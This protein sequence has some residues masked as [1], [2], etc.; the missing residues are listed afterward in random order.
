MTN[1]LYLSYDGI[2]DPLGQ[3]QILPYLKALSQKSYFFYLVGFEKKNTYQKQKE[4]IENEIKNFGI[5][6]IPRKYHKSPPVISTL[7]DLWKM[8]KTAEKIVSE[9]N[10]SIVHCRSYL[11]MLIGLSLKR[12]FNMKLLFDMRGFW[13]D[14]RVDGNIWNLRN[15]VFK[16]VYTYFKKKEMQFALKADHIISL[17]HAGKEEMVSGRLFLD[18]K[19]KVDAGK[20]TVIPCATDLELF[21]PEKVSEQMISRL[22]GELKLTPDDKILLYLGS[23]G[24]WYLVKEMLQFFK[25]WKED[26]PAYK[27]FFVTKDD[28]QLVYRQCKELNIATDSIIHTQANRNDVPTCLKLADL[29]IFFIKPVYSKKASSAVKMGEMMAMGLPFVTNKGVGDV[30]EIAE[31]Y[32]KGKLIDL[33]SIATI[34]SNDFLYKTNSF[35]HKRVTSLELSINDLKGIYEKLSQFN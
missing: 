18:K 19:L 10:I 4:V 23:L 33:N 32:T 16:W 14:E 31:N 11:T 25:K 8:N 30:D 3:S 12:K 9:E 29:G 26:H 6:W 7:Y 13:A 28:I 5:Q 27:F 2:T 21:N 22:R 20:I 34:S 35:S 17:T 24:T 1:V 15:P